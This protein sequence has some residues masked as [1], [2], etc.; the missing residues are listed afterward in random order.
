MDPLAP[1][2]VYF[3]FL[4]EAPVLISRFL[5]L[6]AKSP[7]TSGS[8]SWTPSQASL[9]KRQAIHLG[10]KISRPYKTTVDPRSV[11]WV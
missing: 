6:I 2:P 3:G 7:F 9:P 5:E 10:S 11:E 1:G 4:T 8:T